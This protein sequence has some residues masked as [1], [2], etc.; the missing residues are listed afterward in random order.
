MNLRNA[1]RIRLSPNKK[2]RSVQAA[3]IHDTNNPRL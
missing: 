2:D 3:F 1:R